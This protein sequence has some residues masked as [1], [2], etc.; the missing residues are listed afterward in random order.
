MQLD[1]RPNQEVQHLMKRTENE[2]EEILKAVREDS[3]PS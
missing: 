2:G 1:K 3:L